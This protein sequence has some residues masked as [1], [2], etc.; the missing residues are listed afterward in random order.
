VR[1]KKKLDKKY[2]GP[3]R[4]A[5]IVN[6]AAYTLELPPLIGIYPTFYVSLLEK[7][8]KS[9]LSKHL[10]IPDT[11]PIELG[12]DDVYEVEEIKEQ[13]IGDDNR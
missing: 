6:D 11:G 10:E 1:T 4:I 3:F 5:K 8:H 7:R 2:I 13:A 9:V 12:Q